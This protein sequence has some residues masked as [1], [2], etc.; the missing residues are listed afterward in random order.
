MTYGTVHN[1]GLKM[2]NALQTYV[3]HMY[4]ITS[5]PHNE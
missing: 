2:L 5:G 4:Y 1:E 3:V